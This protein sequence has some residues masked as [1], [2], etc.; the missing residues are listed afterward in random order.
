MNTCTFV[1]LLLKKYRKA[2]SFPFV[3]WTTNSVS[4]YA[5]MNLWDEL[6]KAAAGSKVSDYSATSDVT[7]DPNSNIY[8]I[9]SPD[10]TRRISAH[11]EH[12]GGTFYLITKYG[13]EDFNPSKGD[14][15]AWPD[16][17][18]LGFPTDLQRDRLIAC[19]EI[20][21]AYTH[22]D[23]PTL[24]TVED[25]NQMLVEK[26]NHVFGFPDFD[27]FAAPDYDD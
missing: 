27:P 1:D 24:E 2:P 9:I 17:S 25:L 13:D 16:R 21:R 14:L 11:P 6:V 15:D 22:A 5:L 20:I 23:L 8:D 10:K 18:Q 3:D 4:F 26:Y 12:D 19:F 7:M